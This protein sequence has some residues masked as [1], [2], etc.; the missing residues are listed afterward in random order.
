MQG[1][2]HISPWWESTHLQ[3]PQK[4]GTWGD[5]SCKKGTNVLS[6][7][8]Q[9]LLLNPV[10]GVGWTAPSFSL[11]RGDLKDQLVQ[12]GGGGEVVAKPMI[13][14]C[15]EHKTDCGYWGDDSERF[16]EGMWVSHTLP[17]TLQPPNRHYLEQPYIFSFLQ[18]YDPADSQRQCCKVTSVLLQH[19]AAFPELHRDLSS[20]AVPQMITALLAAKKEVRQI[21]KSLT[22]T[23]FSGILSGLSWNCNLLRSNAQISQIINMT[24]FLIH[25]FVE[26][27]PFSF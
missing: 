13:Y 10:L 15:C 19:S 7:L 8:H 1:L 27:T 12:I 22:D 16:A 9:W 20:S 14:W 21:L 25:S 26:E 4:H 6:E 5:Q 2:P 23:H 3:W 11:G 17:P 18:S 24:M